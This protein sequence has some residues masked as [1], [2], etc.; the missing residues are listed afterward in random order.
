MGLLPVIVPFAGL[1]SSDEPVPKLAR[2]K[3]VTG[4][5][6]RLASRLGAS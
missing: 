1:I 2:F 3:R 5:K 4:P 6:V